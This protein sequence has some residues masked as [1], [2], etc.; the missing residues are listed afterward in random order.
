TI[1]KCDWSSD[2]CSSDLV[3]PAQP[4]L[5]DKVVHKRIG[6]VPL[7]GEPAAQLGLRREDG[8]AHGRGDQVPERGHGIL[9]GVA[10]ATQVGLIPAGQLTGM[11][12]SL[13]DGDAQR[14]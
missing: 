8:R 5:A 2:V 4:A 1:F 14:S 9:A 13:A 11:L 7:P 10:A 3:Y 6:P 12:M